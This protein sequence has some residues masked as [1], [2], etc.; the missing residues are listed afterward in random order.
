MKTLHFESDT[1]E[2]MKLRIPGKLIQKK[3]LCQKS[4]FRTNLL[5]K[6]FKDREKYLL[7]LLKQINR[8]M[9]TLTQNFMWERMRQAGL[10]QQKGI[11]TI[12]K[13]H[14]NMV[15][16]FQRISRLRYQ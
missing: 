5:L 2:A 3:Q 16:K 12:M 9:L 1:I 8:G 13:L 14:L 11:D 7:G 6:F 15:K 10:F 4:L